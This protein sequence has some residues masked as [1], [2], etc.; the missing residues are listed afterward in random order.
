MIMPLQTERCKRNGNDFVHIKALPTYL[1][2]FLFVFTVFIELKM[3]M[4]SAPALYNFTTMMMLL[5]TRPLVMAC[6]DTNK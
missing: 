5:I 4:V 2:W 6:G 3:T 1:A